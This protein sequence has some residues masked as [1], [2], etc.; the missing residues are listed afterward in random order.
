M[1]RYFLI[2]FLIFMCVGMAILALVGC[3]PL[4]EG[5]SQTSP[6][7]LEQTGLDA[8]A[9]LDSAD[10]AGKRTEQARA[11]AQKQAE[12]QAA[13]TEGASKAEIERIQQEMAG[14]R[15]A[16]DVQYQGMKATQEAGAIYARMTQQVV[17]TQTAYPQTATPLAA[18]QAAVVRGAQRDE[19]RAYWSQATDPFVAIAPTMFWMTLLALLILGGVMAYRQLMPVVELR[20]RAIRRGGNDAPLV[21]LRLP[22]GAILAYD[23]DRNFAPGMILDHNGATQT[24]A[25][26]DHLQ[27]EVTRRDQAVDAVRALPPII[28]KEPERILESLVVDEGK[29]GGQPLPPFAPWEAEQSYRGEG[30]PLGLGAQG[31]IAT[32]PE[33]SPHLLIAGTTGSGKTRYGLRP[34][35]AS[36]LAEGYQAAIFDRSGLDFQPFQGHPNAQ[37]IRL[38]QPEQ[39]IGYLRAMYAEIERRIDLLLESGA[40]TWGLLPNA[41]PRFLGVFDEFSNLADS[42]ENREREELWRWA[43]MVAAE[44]RKA[45]MHLAL[46]LQD[47]T[48]RSI[49]LRIRR[50]TTPISFRVRD[51]AAS[52][53]V[54][55]AGG[56]EAL[57]PRQFL[58]LIGAA[59]VRGVAFS[60][61]DEQIV[62][63]LASRP[64][65]ELPEAEWLEGGARASHDSPLPEI[66][67]LAEAIRPL[68]EDGERNMSALARAAGGQNAG[69]FHYKLVEAMALLGSSTSTD[70]TGNGGRGSEEE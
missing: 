65:A 42:M 48:H 1:Q 20:L 39:A 18:T 26:A 11:E 6:Y 38:E 57:P 16:F 29:N 7:D 62:Q 14:T 3:E 17:A 58:A 61:D 67:E 66:V 35:I 22:D 54:L 34:V 30:L 60:P 25:A 9:T 24:G 21:M 15:Q 23:P 59:L 68:W 49:D 8:R 45:G 64:V 13:R 55:N 69:S 52:R 37:I 51:D 70:S 31:L 10:L 36:A 41:G 53:V 43:R 46:A 28:H 32:N 56:A 50:N 2:A 44:G 12:I 19:R 40:S 27:A 5:R 47:P 33:L 63:F 4:G